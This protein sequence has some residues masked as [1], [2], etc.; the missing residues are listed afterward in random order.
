METNKL[1]ANTRNAPIF[2]RE[3]FRLL[4]RDLVEPC[5]VCTTERPQG[6]AVLR[7]F[8]LCFWNG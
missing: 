1:V 6:L 5:L 4:G 8:L 3:N 2:L 7:F